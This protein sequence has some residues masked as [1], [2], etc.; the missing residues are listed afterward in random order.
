MLE[1]LLVAEACLR[2]GNAETT[3]DDRNLNAASS[4]LSWILAALPPREEL[5]SVWSEFQLADG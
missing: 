1:N 5:A 2:D 3:K 4:L